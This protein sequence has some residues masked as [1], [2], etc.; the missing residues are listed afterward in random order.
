M[1]T[2]TYI[3]ERDELLVTFGSSRGNGLKRFGPFCLWQ[4]RNGAIRALAVKS[5]SK[6]SD[7]LRRNRGVVHLGGIVRGV[8]ITRKDTGAVRSELALRLLRTHL[9]ERSATQPKGKRPFARLRGIWKKYGD[10]T[11]Q[12]MKNAEYHIPDDVLP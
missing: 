7:E 4:D 8:K 3:P 12:E 5:A 2:I 9:G 11:Y 10:F 1:N 6:E